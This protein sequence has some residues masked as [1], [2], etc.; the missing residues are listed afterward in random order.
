[1]KDSFVG[2]FKFVHRI[3]Q[4]TDVRVDLGENVGEIAVVGFVLEVRDGIVGM[5]G[6]V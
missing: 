2:A 6:C 3:E 1:M 5:C 4:L